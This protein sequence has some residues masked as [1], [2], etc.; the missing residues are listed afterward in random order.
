MTQFFRIDKAVSELPNIYNS[1]NPDTNEK[2]RHS[3]E[4]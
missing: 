2:R 3:A 1:A 4:A